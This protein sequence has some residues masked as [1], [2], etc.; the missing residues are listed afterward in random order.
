MPELTR[1][2]PPPVLY[3]PRPSAWLL[4][5]DYLF[6]PGKRVLDIACGEWRRALTAPQWGGTVT[7][8]DHDESKLDTA[9]EAASRLGVTVD[10]RMVDPQGAA[11]AARFFDADVVS[12]S[13]Y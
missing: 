4:W 10:W 5:H 7:G 9:R 6:G 13:C 8:I 12:H 1:G 11:P 2:A 3:L